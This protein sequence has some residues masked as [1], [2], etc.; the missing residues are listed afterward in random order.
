MHDM[1]LNSNRNEFYKKDE[2]LEIALR[3]LNS[4]ISVN[5]LEISNDFKPPII[6]IMGMARSG[7]TLLHQLLVN[8]GAF[9]YPSNLIARFYSNPGIG[10][11][12]QQ[13]LIEYDPLNQMGF[14][15][16]MDNYVSKLGKTMGAL[17]PSE[18]WYFWR[19]YFKFNNLQ[20]LDPKAISNVNVVDFLNK[21]FAFQYYT[22]K[23]LVMKGMIMNWHIPY[24]NSIYPNFI[25]IDVR[26]DNFLNSQSVLKAREEYFGDREKWYS[27]KPREYDKLKMMNPIQQVAGQ[28]IYTKREIAKGLLNVPPS[29][30]II[31]EYDDICN[32]PFRTVEKLLEKVRPFFNDTELKIV[33]DFNVFQP[34]K[35]LILSDSD[36]VEL[37][38]SIEEFLCL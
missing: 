14:N 7:T 9:S 18:F 21:L 32:D 20:I 29:N 31:L 10:I 28:V 3:T 12:A 16:K 2:K 13:S 38:R 30:K 8:S 33:N 36:I 15:Q 5:S 25:F 17:A 26:R 34:N 37:S 11:L 6:L 35:D 1:Y 22:G 27:F 19:E 23:P 4:S 24:L